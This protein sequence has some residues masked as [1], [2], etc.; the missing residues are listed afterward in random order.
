MKDQG[1]KRFKRVKWVKGHF[2]FDPFETF[3]TFDPF[4]RGFALIE[5]MLVIGIMGILLGIVTINLA[6]VQRN[7]SLAAAT[8]TIISDLKSQQ[9]KAMNGSSETGTSGDSYGVSFDGT[10][11]YV[12]FRGASKAS[13][14]STNMP[15]KLDSLI[16]ISAA[17]VV[18]AQKSGELTTPLS[19]TIT[20]TAGGEQKTLQINKYGA[21]N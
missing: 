2:T 5:L 13:N 12:L 15:V 9:L 6:K 3:D 8:E 10:N 16:T 21:I 18:F 11:T 17:S 1:I 19:I 20:N 14:P 7:T 4:Q